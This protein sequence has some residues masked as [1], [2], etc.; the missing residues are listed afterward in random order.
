LEAAPDGS[1]A[2]IAKAWDEEI[3]RRVTGMEAGKTA[4]IPA[5]VV[6]ARLHAKIEN[7]R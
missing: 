7:A 4:W 2:A 6:L 1:P 3:R 5:E